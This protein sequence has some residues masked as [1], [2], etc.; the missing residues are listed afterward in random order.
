MMHPTLDEPD[1]TG[2]YLVMSRDLA[3]VPTHRNCGSYFVLSATTLGAG[4]GI[5]KP[6]AVVVDGPRQIIRGRNDHDHRL[7][8]DRGGKPDPVVGAWIVCLTI[9]GLALAWS[10][11]Q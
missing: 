6:T 2:F 11:L 10:G 7:S 1:L 8:R 9:A 3:L 5:T 4:V